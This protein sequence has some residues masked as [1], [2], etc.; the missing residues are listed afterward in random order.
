MNFLLDRF[1]LETF[2]DV[3]AALKKQGDEVP[4]AVLTHQSKQNEI[5]TKAVCFFDR[6]IARGLIT[7]NIPMVLDRVDFKE[8][9][10]FEGLAVSVLSRFSIDQNAFSAQEMSSHYFELYNFWVY[11]LKKYKI[12]FCFQHYMPHDPSSFVLYLVL[13]SKKIPVVFIDVPHIFNK[14]RALSCS[15]ENRDILILSHGGH[16]SFQFHDEST[17]YQ[18]KLF[19]KSIE[20]IPRTVRFRYEGN[21][22]N[23]LLLISKKL[24]AAIKKPDKVIRLLF[25]FSN[26]TSDFFKTSRY[27]WSSKLSEFSILGFYIFM[28][29]LALGLAFR[30]KKYERA[31]VS[32][33][34]IKYV[35]FA[36]SAQPEGTTLPAALEFR[37]VLS[38]LKLLREAIP[39]EIPILY[40]ENP[41]VFETRNPYLSAVKYRSPDFYDLLIR[42]PNVKLVSTEMDSHELIRNAMLVSTINGTAALEAIYFE[43]PAITF[44]S[45]W[46]DGLDG[47]HKY[48][49]MNDLMAFFKRV[50][51][52]GYKPKPLESVISLDKDMMVEF[53]EHSPYEFQGNAR[54][55]LVKAFIASVDKFNQLDERKW[56]I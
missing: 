18:Y 9:S 15:F 47:I 2:K 36:M 24:N 13:K 1:P 46:Y 45:N 21:K 3:E 26:S 8:A 11:Q 48:K 20:S 4:L 44:G 6:D 32:S 17:Q 37:D 28:K 42:I 55:Q 25:S 16:N 30:K 50:D 41:S 34:P 51:S 31:C 19:S 12:D 52:D 39:S 33:L 23:K 54:H 40:K 27:A 35:Y 53:E 22:K 5:K 14:Y 10:R 56:S 43:T 7:S 29:K 38:V 49:S